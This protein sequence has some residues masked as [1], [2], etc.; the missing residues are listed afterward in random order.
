MKYM[1][2]KIFYSYYNIFK[3]L[4]SADYAISVYSLVADQV[5]VVLRYISMLNHNNKK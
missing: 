3:R 4:T 2:Y 5:N 1:I